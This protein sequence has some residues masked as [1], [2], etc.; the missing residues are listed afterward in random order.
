LKITLKACFDNILS[1]E[2]VSKSIKK[3][4]IEAFFR[5]M[6][7]WRLS[8]WILSVAYDANENLKVRLKG[9]LIG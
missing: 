8:A 9:Q 2:T 7:V 3:A 6:I 5:R 4:H 1:P